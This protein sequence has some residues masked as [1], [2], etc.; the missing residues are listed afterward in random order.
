MKG[1]VE[2]THSIYNIVIVITGTITT[3]NVTIVDCYQNSN[4]DR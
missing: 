3:A 1:L 4:T 2:E